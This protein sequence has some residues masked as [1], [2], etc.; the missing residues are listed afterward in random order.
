MRYRHPENQ[1]RT[2]CVRVATRFCF[3]HRSATSCRV[4]SLIS[5]SSAFFTADNILPAPE[6]RRVVARSSFFPPLFL[7]V[8]TG[9]SRATGIINP[10]APDIAPRFQPIYRLV[11]LLQDELFIATN[12]PTAKFSPRELRAVYFA[13]R[14]PLHSVRPHLRPAHAPASGAFFRSQQV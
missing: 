3:Q 7:S 6:Q 13:A 9:R 12:Y 2:Q 5:L 14:R 11:A 8:S 10:A 1:R 4:A